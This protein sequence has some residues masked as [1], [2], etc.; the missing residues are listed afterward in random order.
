MGLAEEGDRSSRSWK[1][2]REAVMHR[3]V[4]QLARGAHEFTVAAEA[5]L[6]YRDGCVG[7]GL[8]VTVTR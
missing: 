4:R 6:A 2:S 8:M 1:A 3:P 7:R 5:R